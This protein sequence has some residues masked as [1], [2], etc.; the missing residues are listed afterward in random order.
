MIYILTPLLAFCSVIYEL[1]LGQTLSAFLGNTVLRYSVTI[2]LYMLSM[3][4]GAFFVRGV[5]SKNPVISLQVVEILL[6]IIG[7]ASLIFLFFLDWLGSPLLLF[8][9]V[10][11]SLI[12]IIGILT[13]AEIPL[14][15]I[16]QSRAKKNSESKVLGVDYIGA[17]IG[18]IAFAF[19]FYPHAGLLE[20]SLFVALVNA[21][22][23][24][25]LI[26]QEHNV[27]PESHRYFNPLLV[28]QGA[29]LLLLGYALFESSSLNE[30]LLQLYLRV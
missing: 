17:F 12:I 30:F 22:I 19:Y 18:T 16:I 3:G 2:G 13:G 24:L 20:T 1:L 29:V 10:A 15:M 6:S 25:V 5:V 4:I 8:S 14:L 27:T 26:G 11:H 28:G 9:L 7:G 23:G 21:F